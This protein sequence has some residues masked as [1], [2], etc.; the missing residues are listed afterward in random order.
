VLE[1]SV[2]LGD[3]LEIRASNLGDLGT[4]ASIPPPDAGLSLVEAER[5]HI[6]LVLDAQ[7][8]NVALAAAVLGLS[9]S[10]LYKKLRGPGQ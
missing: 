8:G 1:R 7:G 5:R 10:G 6:Q 2:L 4:E 3:G 9:R